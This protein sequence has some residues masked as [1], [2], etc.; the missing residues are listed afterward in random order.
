MAGH[1]GWSSYRDYTFNAN[2]NEI[3]RSDSGKAREV[4]NYMDRIRPP[5]SRS[6]APTQVASAAFVT[7]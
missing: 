2:S 7:R 4:A 6:T 5:V 1:S 3:L